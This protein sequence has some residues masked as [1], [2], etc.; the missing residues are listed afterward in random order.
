MH[1]V[2]SLCT[3]ALPFA[4]VRSDMCCCSWQQPNAGLTPAV[5]PGYM[6]VGYSCIVHAA[7]PQEQTTALLQPAQL[8]PYAILHIQQPQDEIASQDTALQVLLNTAAIRYHVMLSRQRTL[9]LS[10]CWRASSSNPPSSR[11]IALYM[12]ISLCS[13]ASGAL[14]SSYTH[15]RLSAIT[16][17]HRRYRI[18]WM[19]T[20]L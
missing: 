20:S 16:N 8:I 19:C 10:R 1:A 14:T 7:H 3:N 17:S 4:W 6:P 18:A 5:V 11:I 12:S 2:E 13:Y 9:W 15:E